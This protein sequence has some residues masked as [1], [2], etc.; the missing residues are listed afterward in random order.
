MRWLLYRLKNLWRRQAQEAELDAE[1]QFHIEAEAEEQIARGLS[2]DDARQAA[3]RS[4]GNIALAKEDARAVWSW[5]PVERLLQDV[6]YAL[7]PDSN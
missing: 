4:L 5:G 3:R 7:H 2:A 6:R 1:L